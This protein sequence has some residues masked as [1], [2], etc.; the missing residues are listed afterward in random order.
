MIYNV[1][2]AVMQSDV[3]L[4]AARNAGYVYV[5][6]NNLPN[7]YDNLPSYWDQEVSK[8]AELNAMPEPETLTLLSCALLSC[9]LWQLRRRLRSTKSLFQAG[10]RRETLAATCPSRKSNRARGVSC[11]MASRGF[12]FNHVFRT[13]A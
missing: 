3:A 5:T 1:S 10:G 12:L 2:T 11:G 13:V 4:A 9:G 6:D 8:I 7:P